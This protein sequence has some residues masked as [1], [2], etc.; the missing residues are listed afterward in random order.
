MKHAIITLFMTLTMVSAFTH[1]VEQKYLPM[2]PEF[3]M[4]SDPET[5]LREYPLGVIT[6]QAAFSHHG[7]ATRSVKMPNGHEGWVY[8]FGEET[9][10]RTY[11]LEIDT[12]DRVVDVLYNERGRHNG[13]TALQLQSQANKILGP[14]VEPQ[15][16]KKHP[17]EKFVR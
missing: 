15:P 14:E 4:D 11:T 1:A 9:W 5:V 13:L 3:S 16:F 6:R 7:Q 10:L 2:P 17:P 12:Q 8:Q